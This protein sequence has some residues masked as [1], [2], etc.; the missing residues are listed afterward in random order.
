[1]DL[2]RFLADPRRRNLAVLGAAALVGLLLALAAVWQQAREEGPSSA[3]AQFFPGFAGEARNVARI[4]IAS[5]AGAFDVTFV[6]EKGWVVPER[7]DYPAAFD[8]V[9]R[10]VVGLAAL[11]T[12]EPKTA[13]PDW[14][15]FVGLGAPPAGD[16]VLIAV[17]DDKGHELASLIAGKSEDIGD[18]SGATG[19]FVRHTGEDQS[20][21]VRSVLDPRAALADWL[22]K[23]VMDVDRARIQEVDV[24]PAGSAS[25]VVARA[26]PSD[27]DFT[28]TPVPA[29]KAVS[30]PTIP[31]G[32][33]AAIT[34]F[35]FDDVRLAREL[36]F[37]NP[38]TTARLVTKTFDGL[39]VTVNVL[40]Q[41]QDYWAILSAEALG[42]AGND[43]AKEASAINA[44]AS[45]WAYK[46]PAFKG[47]LF[48]TTLD[49]LLKAPP[50]APP[51][52]PPQP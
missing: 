13:R 41:G 27:A 39:K 26:R 38:A 24:D 7:S 28:L 46:L 48:M 12:I 1:M 51:G 30:D 49:S 23:H 29:G 32:V 17:A 11:Q 37:S 15:H 50:A 5:K 43:A 10:T 45:G 22:D 19:L 33:A 44:R 4:H 36:D 16:G 20:W 47:Q 42:P 3:P 21:L 35:G 18:P 34:G 9:Q 14:L 8:L 31:D 25:F 6:P 52:A 2:N 40:K